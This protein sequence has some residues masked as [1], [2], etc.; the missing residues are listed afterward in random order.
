MLPPA[1]RS[2]SCYVF[3]IRRLPLSV[4]CKHG[5]IRRAGESITHMQQGRHHMTVCGLKL[6]AVLLFNTHIE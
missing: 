2:G 4:P 5:L 3:T 6:Y 1:T